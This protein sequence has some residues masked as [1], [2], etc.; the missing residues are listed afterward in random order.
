MSEAQLRQ[1][2]DESKR[3]QSTAAGQAG[4]EDLSD[5]VASEGAKSEYSL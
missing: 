3:S 2:Y 4:R 1:R 5:V